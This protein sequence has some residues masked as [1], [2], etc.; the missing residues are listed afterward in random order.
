M[1]RHV[2]K[3][4]G[5]EQHYDERKV[6]ASVYAAAINCHYSEPHAELLARD[7]MVKVNRWVQD[8][9]FMTSEQIKH[10]IMH[11]LKDEDHEVRMMYES[12]LD[13]C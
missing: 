5:H 4:K 9:K 10:E 8:R 12:H 13:L 3:R 6:Y 11:Q 7:V 2:V 1:V